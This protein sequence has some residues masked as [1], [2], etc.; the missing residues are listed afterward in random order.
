MIENL[1]TKGVDQTDKIGALKNLLDRTFCQIDVGMANLQCG[2]HSDIRNVQMGNVNVLKYNSSG[3]QTAKRS[4]NHIRHD[5]EDHYI[6][7]IPL[8]NAIVHMEQNG[9][10]SRI[11][12]GTFSFIHTAKPFSGTVR[13][14]NGQEHSTYSTL[15]ARIPAPFLRERLPFFDRYCNRTFSLNPGIS[16]I[17]ALTLHK[18]L[19]DDHQLNDM[20]RR[21]T[22][23][24]LLEIIDTVAEE[25]VLGMENEFTPPKSMRQMTIEKVQDYVLANLSNPDLSTTYIADKCNISLRYLHSVF[26]ETNWTIASWIKEQ[27]LLKCRQALQDP[28]QNKLSVTQIAFTWGFNDA[29]HFSRAYKKRFFRTPSEDR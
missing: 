29:S 3:Q 12:P 18:I 8:D 26:E 10:Y 6:L 21:H 20:Q 13:A 27:R 1:T 28:N 14:F 23:Q 15:H 2:S 11:I 17:M 16:Q 19:C 25:A 22:R 4:L 5:K 7:Y 9:K 24:I